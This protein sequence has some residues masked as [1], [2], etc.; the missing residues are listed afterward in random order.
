MPRTKDPTLHTDLAKKQTFD[1][2]RLV[3]KERE[4]VNR[5]LRDLQAKA[6]QLE[7]Q[8]EQL[9]KSLNVLKVSVVDGHD[10]T[11]QGNDDDGA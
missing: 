4:V 9:R 5:K 1:A 8:E 7:R 10:T 2:Y 11:F 3:K 6:S